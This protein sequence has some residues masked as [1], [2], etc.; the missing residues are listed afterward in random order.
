MRYTLGIVFTVLL[1]LGFSWHMYHNV[2]LKRSV[3]TAVPSPI[4]SVSE[5]SEAT[6][7]PEATAR[8]V[9]KSTENETAQ[10]PDSPSGEPTLQSTMPE[11]PG[12]KIAYASRKVNIRHSP[13]LRA[14]VVFVAPFNTQLI[15]MNE[16]QEQDGHTWRQVK[17][18]NGAV[19]W[20]A[21]EFISEQQA[22]S[23]ETT[24]TLQ[25][26]TIQGEKVN[27]RELPTIQSKVLRVVT[28]GTKVSVS[29]QTIQQGGFVW[30]RARFED[31]QEGWVASQF[32]QKTNL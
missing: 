19:G 2:F 6:P 13:T 31:G 23:T 26:S 32:V 22:S 10:L 4:P 29:P 17:L 25:E 3:Y 20:I 7:I 27:I 8:I 14:S 21:S 12:Q 15:L 30:L 28:S 9:D 5:T 1:C 11:E 18:P 24:V 16:T